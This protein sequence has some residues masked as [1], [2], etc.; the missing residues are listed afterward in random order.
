MKIYVIYFAENKDFIEAQSFAFEYSV[1]AN[2][3]DEAREKAIAVFNENNP[4]L[5]IN[6]YTTGFLK[7]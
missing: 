2:S 7:C 6:N 4:E 3:E 1:N 5:S